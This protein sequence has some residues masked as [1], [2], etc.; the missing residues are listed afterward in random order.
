MNTPDIE[1]YRCRIESARNFS[2]LR[3]YRSKLREHLA[4]AAHG[5]S[6]PG[7]LIAT[8]RRQGYWP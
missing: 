4:S 8:A 5:A 1:T 3:R 2:R 6:R 7:A